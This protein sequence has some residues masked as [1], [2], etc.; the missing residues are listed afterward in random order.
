MKLL[1]LNTHSL[2]GDDW[3]QKLEW[4]VE[5]VLEEKPDIIA[6]QEENQTM[7]AQE[8]ENMLTE[9]QTVV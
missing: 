5:G 7:T 3:K 9:G 2:H 8:E 4:F 1:T 6:L